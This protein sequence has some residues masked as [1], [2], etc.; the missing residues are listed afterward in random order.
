MFLFV[1]VDQVGVEDLVQCFFFEVLNGLLVWCMGKIIF[2]C[3]LMFGYFYI[4]GL[5]DYVN[6]IYMGEIGCQFCQLFI[7][8]LLINMGG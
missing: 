6:L 8:C 1:D 7:G 2:E 3:G 5:G 4:V